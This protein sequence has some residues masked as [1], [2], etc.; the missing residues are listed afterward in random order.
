MRST[1]S[2]LLGHIPARM[3]DD[4]LGLQPTGA[5]PFQAANPSSTRTNQLPLDRDVVRFG[6]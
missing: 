6:P 5:L 3:W 1:P 2:P 4:N